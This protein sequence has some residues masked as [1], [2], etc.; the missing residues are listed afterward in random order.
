MWQLGASH[1]KNPILRLNLKFFKNIYSSEFFTFLSLCQQDIVH[2]ENELRPT[3]DV[4]DVVIV[5]QTAG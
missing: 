5:P 1:D 4:L 3:E 2:A